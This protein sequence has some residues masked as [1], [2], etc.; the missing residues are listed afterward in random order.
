MDTKTQIISII[1]KIKDEQIL[2]H[3]LNIVNKI[4]KLHIDGR[5]GR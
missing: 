2:K 3:V 4:Y 5:W 1:N